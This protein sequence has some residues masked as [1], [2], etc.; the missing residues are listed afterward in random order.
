MIEALFL[1]CWIA[2]KKC[3]NR[4]CESTVTYLCDDDC[5]VVLKGHLINEKHFASLKS[6]VITIH[7]PSYYFLSHTQTYHILKYFLTVRLTLTSHVWGDRVALFGAH[8]SS[9]VQKHIF[10]S[11]RPTLVNHHQRSTSDTMTEQVESLPIPR[12][13][14]T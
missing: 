1:A 8:R 2:S 4:A 11:S 7:I 10:N 9:W 5:Y 14:N 13:S 3:F 6:C 12:C